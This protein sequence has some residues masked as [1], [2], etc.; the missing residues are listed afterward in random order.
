MSRVELIL[1]SGEHVST[2]RYKSAE[3]ADL[4]SAGSPLLVHGPDDPWAAFGAQPSR[5]FPE[6]R[7]DAVEVSTWSVHV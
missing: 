5:Q 4:L 3:I 7:I 1:R 2:G 6:R